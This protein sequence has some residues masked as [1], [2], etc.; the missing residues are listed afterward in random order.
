MC[1]SVCYHALF[2]RKNFSVDSIKSPAVVNLRDVSGVG[3]F[4][5]FLTCLR[6]ES[7]VTSV[8]LCSDFIARRQ[9]T[10]R[11]CFDIAVIG[12]DIDTEALRLKFLNIGNQYALLN[13]T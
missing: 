12:S 2:G 9:W 6:S 1:S 4:E 5:K 11:Q 10:V 3:V 13:P 8:E 7:N